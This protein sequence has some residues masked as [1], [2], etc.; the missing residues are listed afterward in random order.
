MRSTERSFVDYDLLFWL[1]QA[2]LNF[3]MEEIQAVQQEIR[4]A[5]PAEEIVYYN[6]YR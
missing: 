1:L 2:V 5:L 6:V 4:V 3:G